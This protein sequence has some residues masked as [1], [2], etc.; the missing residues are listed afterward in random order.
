MLMKAERMH[1]RWRGGDMNG[2]I[3]MM[4]EEGGDD[5]NMAVKVIKW[6]ES[7]M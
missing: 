5:G 4:A 3:V 1:S 6:W 7:L 2:R